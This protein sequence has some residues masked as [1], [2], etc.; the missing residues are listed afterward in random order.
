MRFI[1]KHLFSILFMTNLFGVYWVPEVPTPGGDI[2]IFY[3][4]NEGTL[5]PNT[6]PVYIHIGHS[7]WESVDD[8]AM[9]YEPSLGNGWWSFNYQITEDAET[10]D[11]VFTDLLDN[12]DNNGGF[13]I[14]WHISLSYYWTPF[15]PGPN[16]TVE[17]LLGGTENSGSIVWTVDDGNGFN[18]PIDQYRPDGS[19]DIEELPWSL[20]SVGSWISSPLLAD[21]DNL[22]VELGPFNLG[23]QIVNSVKF[24]ILWEDGTWDSGSNNQILFYDINMDFQIAENDPNVIFI[25]PTP[26]SGSEVSPPV[27]IN[28]VGNASNVEFWLNGDMIG[29]DDTMPFSTSWNPLDGAFGDYN[30]A[31][32]AENEEGR[33]SFSFLD[34]I[35]PYEVTSSPVPVGVSDGLNVDGNQ[36]IISLYAPNKEYVSIK[37]SWNT[38][39]PNG[40]LMY[41]SGDSLWWYET[42]LTNGDYEYQFN[43]EGIKNIADPWSKDVIWKDPNGDWESGF[44]GHAKTTFSVGGSNFNWTDSDFIR[45]NQDE[46]II[47]ELHIGDFASDGVT[48][49]TFNDVTLAIESGYFDDLGINVIELLPVNEFEGGYS[50]GV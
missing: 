3:N 6:N 19:F 48:H 11:F 20:G 41:L 38:A 9:T 17:I 50:W 14:D 32:K 4:A 44:Y 45:P 22:I 49:G 23:N 33:V 25:S 39:F 1:Y 36:V 37:G 46:A 31:V 40:E 35:L 7:G 5:P 2:T 10:I 18:A 30:I 34:F 27:T 43:I 12:W 16:D 47:Y 21:D 28:A 26:A 42:T 15:T 8:Y 13:G 29:E 24:A